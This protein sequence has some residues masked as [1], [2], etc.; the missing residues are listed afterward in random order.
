[1]NVLYKVWKGLR[2]RCPHCARE[3]LMQSFL[4]FREVCGQCGYRYLPD[5]GDFWGQVVLAYTFGGIAG[6]MAGTAL[7]VAG[8]GDLE[9]RIYV[10]T[11]AV[12]VAV[13]ASFPFAKALWIHFLYLTRG[14]YEEYA[15]PKREA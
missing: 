12:V 10:S 13:V 8:W 4:R 1:M 11:F 3:G 6:M 14:R 2:L 7:T 5:D 9:S 15:P